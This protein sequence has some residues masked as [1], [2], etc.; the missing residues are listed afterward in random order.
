MLAAAHRTANRCRNLLLLQDHGQASDKQQCP[1]AVP[2]VARKLLWD[3][4]D[5]P[6]HRPEGL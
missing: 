3:A 2:A 6:S 5:Y 1:G 4:E